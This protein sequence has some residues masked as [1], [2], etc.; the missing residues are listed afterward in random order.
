MARAQRRKLTSYPG[1]GVITIFFFGFLY[2]PI[3]VLI[4]F[5]FNSSVSISVWETFSFKWYAEA[6]GNTDLQKAV[7]NTLLVAVV[8]TIGA[9]LI[10]LP[11]AVVLTG[12]GVSKRAASTATGLMSLPLVVP[13]IVIAIAT[14]VF[15]TSVGIDLGL[16]NVMIAHT[17]FCVPFA[18]LP[19]V[20]RLRSLDHRL[21]E[22]AYDLYAS[23]PRAFRLITLPLL[24]PGVVSGAMLAF[25]VSFDNFI[26]TLMVAGAGGTTLPLYIY[27]LVKTQ[28][29]PELNAVS[30]G[31]LLLSLVLLTCAYVLTGGR[32]AGSTG[33][34]D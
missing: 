26:I 34:K 27:G 33:A 20:A 11:A 21:S 16:G 3:M 1:F 31:V 28:I 29:T 7:V 24:A 22:A 19:I 30:T 10:A 18:L 8:A 4:A 23:R 13:E 5:S 25:I 12:Q 17:V 32:I 15:F 14:L 9:V 6:I 2:L